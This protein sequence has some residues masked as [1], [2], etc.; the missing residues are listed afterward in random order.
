VL[1]AL[2]QQDES[3][4]AREINR[5]N[6]GSWQPFIK[7]EISPGDVREYGDNFAIDRRLGYFVEFK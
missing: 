7:Q 4:Q 3:G 1:D 2:N 6:S 5:F